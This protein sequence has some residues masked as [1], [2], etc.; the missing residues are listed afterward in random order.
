MRELMSGAFKVA[1][2]TCTVLVVG[3]SGSL[4][5][6]IVAELDLLRRGHKRHVSRAGPKG[7]SQEQVSNLVRSVG[8]RNIIQ[9][10][11]TR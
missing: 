10:K 7:A 6:P 1:R 11:T 8:G 2:D 5:I 4:G 3:A 9:I